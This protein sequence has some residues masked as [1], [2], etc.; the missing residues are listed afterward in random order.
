MSR[1]RRGA[2]CTYRRLCAARGNEGTRIPTMT[3][4]ERPA[5]PFALSGTRYKPLYQMHYEGTVS[6]T[7]RHWSLP[8]Q[9]T[10]RMGAD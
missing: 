5:L 9:A 8:T 4:N 7:I 2:R 1:A 6:M 10:R 3:Y